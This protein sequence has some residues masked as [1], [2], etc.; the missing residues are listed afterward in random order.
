[1]N[2][3]YKNCIKRGQHRKQKSKSARPV[4]RINSEQNVRVP[5]Q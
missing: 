3:I 4:R 2:Q 1:M 5:N